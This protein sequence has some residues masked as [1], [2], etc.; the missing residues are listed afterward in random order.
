MPARGPKELQYS[1]AEISDASGVFE[2]L[3]AYMRRRLKEIKRLGPGAVERLTG[4]WSR[5]RTDAISREDYEPMADVER[6][7]QIEAMTLETRDLFDRRKRKDDY[8][9][10]S[11]DEAVFEVLS[12]AFG[13]AK[14][15]N[16]LEYLLGHEELAAW[17]AP[18]LHADFQMGE[19]PEPELN[20]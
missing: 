9:V 20:F 7:R 8:P 19:A 18:L 5:D 10:L 1:K 6:E 12:R 17:R 3:V 13:E 14:L 15:K 4:H 2:R 11:E 16:C